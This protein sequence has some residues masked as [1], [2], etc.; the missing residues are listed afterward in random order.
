MCR[1]GVH[2]LGRLFGPWE[3]RSAAGSRGRIYQ[4]H[5]TVRRRR[6]RTI[7]AKAARRRAATRIVPMLAALAY[8]AFAFDTINN[9]KFSRLELDTSDARA[10][11]YKYESTTISPW[12]DIPF[13]T[14]REK[15]GAPGTFNMRGTPLLSF[16]CEIPRHTAEKFEI[17]KGEPHNPLIQDVNKDGTPR[18]Y[19]YSP[20]I[21]NYGAIA[22]TWRDPEEPDADTGLGGDN[23]LLNALQLNDGS[24][25]RGAVQRVRALGALALIDGNE[26][27]WKLLVIDVDATDA[28]AWRDVTDVPPARVDEVR[29]WYRLYKTAEGKGENEYGLDG[30]AARE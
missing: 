25:E 24:C 2:P 1:G 6:P 7:Q 20:A 11:R 17:H 28:P 29:E 3:Q 19:V 8:S 21:V 30:C 26:T 14:G 9:F 10:I 15:G 4:E 23:S 13:T 5:G 16:V 27:D 22:Q 18:S 12:H